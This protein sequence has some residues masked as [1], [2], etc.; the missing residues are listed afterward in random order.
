MYNPPKTRLLADAESR[1]CQTVNG[2]ELFVDQA[3]LQFTALTGLEAPR[4]LMHKTAL[5][6]AKG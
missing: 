2:L 6:Q 4:A 5:A 1:G 3:V